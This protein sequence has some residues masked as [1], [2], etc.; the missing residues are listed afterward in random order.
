VPRAESSLLEALDRYPSFGQDENRLTELFAAILGH[1][2]ELV[3]WLAHKAWGASEETARAWADGGYRVSTQT[4]ISGTERP[5][6]R[7]MFLGHDRPDGNGRL[8]CEHKLTAT[9]TIG[10]LAGYPGL[11][12]SD[13]VMAIRS[14]VGPPVSGFAVAL[15]WNDV[16]ARADLLAR[17]HESAR[18]GAGRRWESRLSSADVD[19][20]QWRRYELIKYLR[21]KDPSVA[22][23]EP[24]STLDVSMYARA[25]ATLFRARD[26]WRLVVDSTHLNDLI[27]DEPGTDRQSYAPDDP[28]REAKEA[29]D[30]WGKVL[31]ESWPAVAS[32]QTT[33]W[34]ELLLSPYD[35]WVPEP[36]GEPA[37]GV[38]YSFDLIDGAWPTSLSP[39]STWALDMAKDGIT[40]NASDYGTIGRCFKTLYLGEIAPRG[41]SLVEQADWIALWARDSMTSIDGH[42]PDKLVGPPPAQP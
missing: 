18:S 30:S 12:T 28:P 11:R 37:F 35:D 38:G 5:D 33:Y 23:A 2:R 17:H 10:Q 13:R 14:A 31:R 27:S 26:L 29:K 40:V 22:K 19:A 15:T 4:M 6:L 7:V 1:D 20:L 36:T 3:A 9:Q 32:H 41:L 21:R 8:F 39:G 16:A 25:R 34:A 42:E 24:F